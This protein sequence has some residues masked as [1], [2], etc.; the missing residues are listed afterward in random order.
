MASVNRWSSWETHHFYHDYITSM[1][2]EM[3]QF[4]SDNF[5]RT[6]NKV[7]K[8]VSEMKDEAESINQSTFSWRPAMKTSCWDAFEWRMLNTVQRS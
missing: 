5:V 7:G 1:L 2:T 3:M 6:K 4:R 8:I